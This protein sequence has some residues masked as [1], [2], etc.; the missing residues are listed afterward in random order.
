MA[1]EV[2]NN[3]PRLAA[4]HNLS[5]MAPVLRYRVG[6]PQALKACIAA[7]LSSADVTLSGYDPA[8]TESAL[9]S[10]NLVVDDSTVLSEPNAIARFLGMYFSFR[11]TSLVAVLPLAR[12][13]T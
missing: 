4:L 10:V 3:T 2:D 11:P 9:L 6:D 13:T 7:A 8:S 12:S 5:G 1:S